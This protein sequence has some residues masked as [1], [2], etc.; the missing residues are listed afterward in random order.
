MFSY[1]LSLTNNYAL[2]QDLIQNVF[3][4][5]WE[6]RD[7]LNPIYPIK[8]FLYK[9]AYNEFV[10]LY[11]K[12]LAISK[13]ESKFIEAI[14]SMPSEENEEIMEKKKAIVFK[15][16]HKL[17]PKCR[18]VF[19]LSKTEGLTNPEIATHLGISIKAA[20]A[21]ITMAYSTLRKNCIA[22]LHTIVFLVFGYQL[23]SKG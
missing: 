8:S 19:L 22:K 20:E 5:T 11:H 4:K 21:Q 14:D 13:V 9:A 18:E 6:H 17:Q 15:E 16:I 3:L 1:A 7:K 23:R 12:N 2:T 10:N